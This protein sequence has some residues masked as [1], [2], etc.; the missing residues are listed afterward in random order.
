MTVTRANLIDHIHTSNP[1][2]T[3]VQAREAVETILGIIMSRLENGN[4]VLLS[5]FGKFN[6]NSSLPEKEEILK[7]EKP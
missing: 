3:K 5:G 1:K 6:V 2:M 7:Q 4:G